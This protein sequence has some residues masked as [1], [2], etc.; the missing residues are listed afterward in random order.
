[1]PAELFAVA[2]NW[3][4]PSYN[5]EDARRLGQENGVT[6]FLY[7][8]YETRGRERS[9]VGISNDITSR[10][11]SRHHV[12]GDWED[13]QFE[14]WLGIVASQ[15]EPGRKPAA[16]PK[17]H[18]EAMHFAEHATAYFIETSENQRKNKSPPKRSG[19]LFNRWFKL[20]EDWPRH[21]KRPTKTWPDFVEYDKERG[22]SRNVYFGGTVE[23]RYL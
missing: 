6:D 5:I 13:D 18:S 10:I 17:I 23:K 9:Y 1:V 4:G 7:V 22:F 14:F 2:V 8:G 12:L 15:S 21:L 20:E 3:Y 19:I 11:T 16:S